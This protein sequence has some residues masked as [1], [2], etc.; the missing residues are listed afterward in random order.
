VFGTKVEI[1]EVK[2]GP[3]EAGRVFDVRMGLRTDY[4]NFANPAVIP[5]QLDCI[6]E[7]DDAITLNCK[8]FGFAGPLWTPCHNLKM[9]TDLLRRV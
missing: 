1:T 2:R 8:I 5:Q 3:A 7:V 4:H 6:L 9:A